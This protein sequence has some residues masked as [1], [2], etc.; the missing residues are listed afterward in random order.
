MSTPNPTAP[1]ELRIQRP[2]DPELVAAV[3][4][5]AIA[6]ATTVQDQDGY[7]M[8][9]VVMRD[10]K[11][12]AKRLEE[13]RVHLK[14]PVLEMSRRVDGMFQPAI[15]T[16]EEAARIVEGNMLTYRRA[17]A[18]KRVEEERK[19]R[20]TAEA[21]QRRRDEQARKD[22]DAARAA[23]NVETAAQIEDEARTAP[24]IV[25]AV[26]AAPPPTAAGVSARKIWKFEITDPAKVPREYLL[27]DESKIRKV[28]SAFKGATAIAG[29]RVYEDEILAAA[30]P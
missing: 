19:A 15:K 30:R 13:A 24:P 11:G 16:F 9:G 7:D 14:E 22:A 23:G 29:V 17:E 6:R 26:Q 10:F 28:V 21:E 12:K 8:A 2:Q 5:L 20:E 25:P 3:T 1:L 18:N 4:A 27:V